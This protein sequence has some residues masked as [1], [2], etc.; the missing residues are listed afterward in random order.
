MSCTCRKEPGSREARAHC[1]IG[2][3]MPRP[4]SSKYITVPHVGA[5]VLCAL[6][7]CIYVYADIDS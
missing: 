6:H 3:D 5:Y 1:V 2:V 7:I 4:P